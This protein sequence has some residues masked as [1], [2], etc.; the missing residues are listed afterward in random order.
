MADRG[1]GSPYDRGRA[2]VWYGR[3]YNPHKVV[4]GVGRVVLEN[5]AEE[6]EY[7]AGYCMAGE[8]G[9]WAAKKWD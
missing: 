5:E 6:A 1:P 2:D 3:R 9:D 4:R 7:R 8:S